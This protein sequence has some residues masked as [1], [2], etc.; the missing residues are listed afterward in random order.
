[1]PGME[2]QLLETKKK[3]G[4][5]NDDDRL[6]AGQMMKQMDSDDMIK[7]DRSTNRCD[8]MEG[9]PGNM[10]GAMPNIFGDSN[11]TLS[12]TTTTT[13]ALDKLLYRK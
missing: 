9:I 4:T 10:G 12:T 2:D 8:T 11:L 6:V 3:M 13:S 1:M 5:N 7:N